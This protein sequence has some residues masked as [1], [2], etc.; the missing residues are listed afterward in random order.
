MQHL[1]NKQ[2][3]RNC[4]KWTYFFSHFVS[5][6]K[7]LNVIH[8]TLSI[9]RILTHS[10]QRLPVHSLY[11]LTM[12]IRVPFGRDFLISSSAC[13]YIRTQ[14]TKHINQHQE[15]KLQASKKCKDLHKTNYT[16]W[17]TAGIS[18]FSILFI[19]LAFVKSVCVINL[20]TYTNI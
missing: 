13:K 14:A 2:I 5:L 18:N 17:T 1:S 12:S 9:Y 8:F 16:I 4:T 6:V 3:N 19:Y 11:L 20:L 7:P 10:S 15:G